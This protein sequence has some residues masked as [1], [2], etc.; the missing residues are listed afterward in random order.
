[1]AWG[2]GRPWVQAPV[3]QKKKKYAYTSER[4]TYTVGGT[5]LALNPGLCAS[6]SVP[7]LGAMPSALQ[8]DF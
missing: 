4:V 6:R 1:M 3:L 7:Y 2:I 5:V 8:T